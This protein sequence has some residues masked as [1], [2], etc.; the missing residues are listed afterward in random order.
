[1]SNNSLFDN[2]NC[3][4]GKLGKKKPKKCCVLKHDKTS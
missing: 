4:G 1:M 3:D 2:C